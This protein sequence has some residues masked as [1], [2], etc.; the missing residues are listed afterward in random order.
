M[1][2]KIAIEYMMEFQEKYPDAGQDILLEKLC[3]E[4]RKETKLIVLR[5]LCT[6]I[7]GEAMKEQMTLKTDQAWDVE[8]RYLLG[9]KIKEWKEGI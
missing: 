5:S 4:I 1:S 9:K 2:E 3:T 7:G 6:L 8:K